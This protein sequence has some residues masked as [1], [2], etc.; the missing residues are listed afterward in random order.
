LNLYEV[1]DDRQIRGV[2]REQRN[3]VHARGGRY[4]EVDRSATWSSAALGDGACEAAPFA[5]NRGIDGDRVE[6][7]LYYP[8]SLCPPCAFVG[9]LGDERT[10]VQLDEGGDADRPLHRARIA[11]AEWLDGWARAWRKVSLEISGTDLMD[12]GVP[13]GPAIGAGLQAAFWSK[14]DGEAAGHDDEMRIAL[15]AAT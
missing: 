14:L 1:V 2:G 3:A 6:G 9:I 4:R 15:A 7:G 8:E 11:G 12:A 13:Q 10:E 5:G